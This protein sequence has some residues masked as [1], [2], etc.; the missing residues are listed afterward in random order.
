MFVRHPSKTFLPAIILWIFLLSSNPASLF[1]QAPDCSGAAQVNAGS[2]LRLTRQPGDPVS[3]FQF[4]TLAPGVVAWSASAA[5][6][7]TPPPS[8]VPRPDCGQVAEP[9]R[10]APGSQ[11]L[12]LPTAGSYFVALGSEE[13]LASSGAYKLRVDAATE[14]VV[15][16]KT[17]TLT[18]D[19]PASCSDGGLPTVGGGTFTDGLIVV[20]QDVDPWDCDVLSDPTTDPLVVVVEADGA[21]LRSTLYD[22]ST[23][24]PQARLAE[25]VLGD[26]AKIGAV[27]HP[28][29]HRLVFDS[30]E[31][32]PTPYTLDVEHFDLCQGGEQDDHADTALCAT[33]IS[34]GSQTTGVLDNAYGDDEDRFTFRLEQRTVVA[35]DVSGS[36]LHMVLED[37]DG[38]RLS[39]WDGC[40]D[41]S[42]LVRDLGPGRYGV[43]VVAGASHI[44]GDGTSAYTLS[45]TTIP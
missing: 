3:V 45:V 15:P 4:D 31:T 10:T 5:D 42:Y 19:A 35:L 33:S 14:A 12:R 38:Q 44:G 39:P 43:R 9:I 18:A 40:L 7:D 36:G 30:L 23:C 16:T 11:V 32:T 8:L 22:G 1:G 2:T 17:L 28:G 41:S 26:G 27:F 25:G 24:E 37:A 20:A 34:L 21:M 29:D 13:P 6:L